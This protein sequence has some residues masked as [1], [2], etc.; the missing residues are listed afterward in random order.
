MGKEQKFKSTTQTSGKWKDADEKI[1]TGIQGS[2]RIPFYCHELANNVDEA[3][4]NVKPDDVLPY[5]TGKWNSPPITVLDWTSSLMQG[6][7]S[8]SMEKALIYRH[9]EGMCD[10]IKEIYVGKST[11]DLQEMIQHKEFVSEK[12]KMDNLE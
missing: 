3:I 11:M 2:F 1:R 4:N 9:K 5:L 7:R 6:L 10:K 8:V 12:Y